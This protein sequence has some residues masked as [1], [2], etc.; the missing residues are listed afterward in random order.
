MTWSFPLNLITD[1]L[2]SCTRKIFTRPDTHACR[3]RSR[4]TEQSRW[5]GF[6]PHTFIQITTS[7][8]WDR[9]AQQF[10]TE[11]ETHRSF[12]I[13]EL[14]IARVSERA[15][16]L[17]TAKRVLEDVSRMDGEVAG[18]GVAAPAPA[19]LDPRHP[20]SPALRHRHSLSSDFRTQP[21]T[22]CISAPSSQAFRVGLNYTTSFTETRGK[23][24]SKTESFAHTETSVSGTF[25]VHVGGWGLVT[26]D[27]LQL[28]NDPCKGGHP[29]D[30]LPSF[31]IWLRN[32]EGSL[33]RLGNPAGFQGHGLECPGLGK[34]A[35]MPPWGPPGS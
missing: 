5:S 34:T 3:G 35:G 21:G 15:G 6:S 17:P 31:L 20:P 12:R 23:V 16:G 33:G 9:R 4:V 11:D 13:S 1:I 24:G 10:Q 19:G 22:V 25:H 8:R 7:T 30:L 2:E 29:S 14:W 18:M 28:L 27:S 32:C 26:P